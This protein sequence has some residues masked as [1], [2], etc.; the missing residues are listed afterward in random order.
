MKAAIIAALT[1]AI[2]SAGTATAAARWINGSQI[3]PRSIP[4]N[5][6]VHTPRGTRGVAGA[7][8]P[9]GPQGIQGPQGVQGRAG[10]F[11]P[12]RVAYADSGQVSVA[13]SATGSA[14][15]PCSVGTKAVGGGFIIAHGVETGI[16]AH[17]SAPVPDGSG[18]RVVV[19]NDSASTAYIEAFAVCAS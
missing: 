16:D 7:E 9:Q 1:A 8:G 17:G 18:W 19:V 13:P 10:A 3:R 4:L 6:L 11:D 5:R 2:V 15:A 14:T 12:S